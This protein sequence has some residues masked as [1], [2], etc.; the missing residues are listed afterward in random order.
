MTNVAE[1]AIRNIFRDIA[2]GT[3][4]VPIIGTCNLEKRP[5]RFA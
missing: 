4:F 1:N 5:Q 2:T 3:L